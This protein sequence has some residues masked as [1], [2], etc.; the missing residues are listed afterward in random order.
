M[1]KGICRTEAN[2]NYKAIKQLKSAAQP[3]V[4]A[5]GQTQESGSPSARLGLQERLFLKC[6]RNPFRVKGRPHRRLGRGSAGDPSV[7][8]VAPDRGDRLGDGRSTGGYSS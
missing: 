3:T 5:A 1:L 7:C 2:G 8:D 4:P 6:G